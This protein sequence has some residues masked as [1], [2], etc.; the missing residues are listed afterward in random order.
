MKLQIEVEMFPSISSALCSFH[1]DHNCHIVNLLGSKL[2]ETTGNRRRQRRLIWSSVTRTR[3]RWRIREG[4]RPRLTTRTWWPRWGGSCRSPWWSLWPSWAMEAPT[5]PCQA[6]CRPQR[7][8]PREKKRRSRSL[9]ITCNT[10]RSCLEG[11]R[12]PMIRETNLKDLKS[13]RNSRNR[14]WTVHHKTSIKSYRE[15]FM[16]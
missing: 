15:F 7:S 5:P 16:N 14:L 3:R 10:Q 8:W 12:K 1:C 13:G 6:Q 9:R 11:P 4:R 2:R